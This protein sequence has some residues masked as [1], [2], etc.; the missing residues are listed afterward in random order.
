MQTM[1]VTQNIDDLH[2]RLIKSSQIMKQNSD[3]YCQLTEKTRAAFTPHIYEIHGNVHYMHCS[4]ECE[5]HSRTFMPGPSL[6]EFEA[7]AAEA[8]SRGESVLT[9]EETGKT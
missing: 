2:T 7:A 9:D 1:L 5:E 3:P 8:A 6:E 4:D